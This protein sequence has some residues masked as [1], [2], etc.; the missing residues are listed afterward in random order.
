MNKRDPFNP[1]RKKRLVYLLRRRDGDKC[2]C[3]N[4]IDFSLSKIDPNHK[5]APSIDHVIPR[6]EGGSNKISNLRLAHRICNERRA[7]RERK[8]LDRVVIKVGK[9]SIDPILELFE[10]YSAGKGH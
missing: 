2:F 10:S 3:G 5:K 6:S 1:K 8:I 7:N 9:K 4:L